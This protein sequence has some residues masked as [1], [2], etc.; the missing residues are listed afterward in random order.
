M[1]SHRL[2]LAQPRGRQ[3][4][5]VGFALGTWLLAIG[6][7]AQSPTSTPSSSG[8]PARLSAD[9]DPDNAIFVASCAECHDPA[10]IVHSGRRSAKEWVSVVDDMVRR[11]ARATAAELTV[12]K[13][14]LFRHHGRVNVNKASRDDLAL[15][16][17]ITPVQAAALVEYRT[18]NGEFTSVADIERAAVV[19]SAMLRARR[20]RIAFSGE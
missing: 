12:V 5:A 19:D 1:R 14:Y 3:A 7:Q 10:E 15:V 11:G 17:D 8:A 4:V 18:A 20:D 13:A 9:D 16:L 2:S 6:L